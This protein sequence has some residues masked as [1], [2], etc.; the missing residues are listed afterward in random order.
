LQVGG[1]ENGLLAIRLQKFKALFSVAGASNLRCF[2]V[3]GSKD[4]MRVSF[5]F[6]TKLSGTAPSRLH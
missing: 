1:A 6:G 2:A 5:F 4:A 3:L